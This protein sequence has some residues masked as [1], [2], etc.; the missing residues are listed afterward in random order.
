MRRVSVLG[1]L[2]DWIA[3]LVTLCA[4][5]GWIVPC[6]P[7]SANPPKS[8]V[9]LICSYHPGNYWEDKVLTGV[10]SVFGKEDV[11]LLVEY[12]DARHHPD[13]EQADAFAELIRVKSVGLKPR[14]ILVAD[15][16][17]LDFLLPRR[18]ELFPETPIVF[19]GLNYFTNERIA[20]Q[21]NITGVVE[22]PDMAG[23]LNLALQLQPKTRHVFVVT[24]DTNELNRI[25]VQ[26]LRRAEERFAGRLEFHE[27]FKVTEG[28]L[29]SRVASIP[30]NAV[31]L[32][33]CGIRSRAGDDLSPLESTRLI[34]AVSPVP[35]YN[36]AEESLGLGPIGGRFV[37]GFTQGETAARL[38]MRILNG[39]PADSIPIMLESPSVPMID[40]KQLQRF[41]M[42]EQDLPPE[43][44]FI[45]KP[46][47]FYSRYRGWIWG[48]GAF[49]MLQT[50]MLIVL[51]VSRQKL[52][53][54]E[55]ALRAK[56]EELD[57]FFTSA[58][59]L[60]CI[61]DTDG[62]F[63][64][65][66]PEWENTL[67]YR[68]ED[69]V[70]KKFMDFVH[71]ED[72]E[73]TARAVSQLNTQRSVLSFANRYRCKNGSYRWI[74]WRSFPFGKTIYASARDITDRKRSETERLEMERR[75]QHAQK[76]ESLG[77]LAGGI[78]H[79]FN[80]LLMAILG[81]LGLALDDLS[82]YSPSRP[83]V[84]DAE[85]AAQRAADL[86]RQMLAYSGKGRY[87]TQPLDLS[88]VAE[89]LIHLFKTSI[90]KKIT[91]NLQLDRNLPAIQADAA[92]LQQVLMNL[93]VNAS[94]AIGDQSG[95]VTLSTGVRDC[96][97][98]CLASS[99]LL[100]KPAAGRFVYLEV[101]DTGCGMDEQTQ[102]R[103]FEP[104]FTTKFSG[105]GLGLSA[106]LGIVRGHNGAIMVHSEAGKGTAFDLLFPACDGSVAAVRAPDREQRRSE[107]P[108]YTG[109]VLLVDDEEMVRGLCRA[110]L[111]RLGFS[112]LAASD[113]EQA[114]ELF[115]QRSQQIICVLLDLT[116]P[117]MDGEA[118][119]HALKRIRP[120]I[121]V[122]L[123]SGYNDEDVTRRFAGKGLAGFLQKP[124]QL[125]KLE[126]EFRR[127]LES[128]LQNP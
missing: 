20:G 28:D 10:Q 74:E 95:V 43:T 87:L 76:L 35:Y 66:N 117:R 120:D 1:C 64:R 127:V 110:M 18:K 45:N 70:G 54:A 42:R 60:L 89:E 106:V 32:D 25:I 126:K 15:D 101:S 47:S 22:A 36:L 7:A 86:T 100:E 78:A 119:F 108:A 62:Y 85:K 68:V 31:F 99:R 34:A 14:L 115:R 65:L 122:I 50:W 46:F 26:G 57:R 69:L 23:T 3:C 125:S 27:L 98:H 5:S 107:P 111:E 90:S 55:E 92:Q 114:L 52:K 118:T 77:V 71:P 88:R 4:G 73:D 121:K 16:N 116:M 105:R 113:G 11:E 94:E 29:P 41:G 19:C 37:T 72:S 91:L 13:M 38:A 58:L 53:R 9:L 104:F 61:A 48:V 8:T 40:W 81:N 96:D 112:V 6:T 82:P 17:A 79:D 2:F 12:L 84:Q 44:I 97:A 51:L 56:T 124:F 67:G 33:A 80:N 102:Q 30:P 93:I 24:S 75:I 123:S 63:R 128:D 59:D 83:F 21:K 109:K 49:I 103:L 39:T